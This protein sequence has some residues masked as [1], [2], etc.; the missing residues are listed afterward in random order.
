MSTQQV[1]L[2]GQILVG[3]SVCP[4][5][6]GTTSNKVQGLALS[7]ASAGFQCV[8]SSDVPCALSTSGALGDEFVELPITDAL[9]EVQLL[10][11]G[12]N[13][14]MRLRSYAAPAD[15]MSTGVTLPL[16]GGATLVTEV[17]GQPAVTTTFTAATTTEQVANE[18][19]A[20]CALLG[21]ESIASVESASLVLRG[22]L[23]GPEGSV[24][25]TGGTGQAALGFGAGTNDA[26]GGGGED[27][28]FNGIYLVQYGM[29]GGAPSRIQISGQGIL[30]IFAAGTPA[31]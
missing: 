24:T 3:G 25:V 18:I 31:P 14:L 26:A 1:K 10:Y 15:L 6:C 23:T 29:N 9:D 7:C 28:D 16:A 21:Q 2:T 4:D 17:D 12:S 11:V 8:V 27:I 30:E 22:V 13:A 19:N 5:P 20:A